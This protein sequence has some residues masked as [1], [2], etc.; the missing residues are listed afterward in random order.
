MVLSD[1]ESPADHSA[2]SAGERA[3]HFANNFLGNARF[4]GAAL[5]RPL[6]NASRIGFVSGRRFFYETIIRQSGMNDLTRDRV[7]QGDIRPDIQ[8]DPRV[9]PLRRRGVSRID[10]VESRAVVDSFKNIM[11]EN[12]VR[13][14]RVRSPEND[15][16][17]LF[18]FLIGTR[19]APRPED[20]RQTDDAWSVSSAVATV[21]VVGS[22]DLS[23]KLLRQKV[24]FIGRFRTTENA[25][26]LRSSRSRCGKPSRNPAKRLFPCRI[27][28]NAVHPDHRLG[29]AFI[30][31]S[32][33]LHSPFQTSLSR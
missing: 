24:H 29:N 12:R 8:P 20:S 16:V 2:I 6:L 28:E 11:K 25:E 21:N 22:H 1:S 31:L 3:R 32:H 10:N 5:Q 13:F 19:A 15:E 7:G 18:R 9:R 4:A 23:S 30:S 14:A 26:L 27:L 33:P 17:S